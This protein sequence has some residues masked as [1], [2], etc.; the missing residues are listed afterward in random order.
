MIDEKSDPDVIL[1]YIRKKL[2]FLEGSRYYKITWWE[3]YQKQHERPNIMKQ[4]ESDKLQKED[5]ATQ[6]TLEA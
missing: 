2:K 6:W 1:R 3:D 5:E 4:I